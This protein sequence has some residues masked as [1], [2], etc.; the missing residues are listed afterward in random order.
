MQFVAEQARQRHEALAAKA[1]RLRS[2]PDGTMVHAPSIEQGGYHLFLSHV[3]GTG[4]DQMRIVKQRLLEMVPGLSIFLDVDDLEDISNLQGYVDRTQTVLVFCSRG[5][6]T[7]KNC[8]IELRSTVAKGKPVLALL[9]PEACHGGLT[10][11]EVREQLVK[12]DAYYAKWGFGDD[13]PRGAELYDALFHDEPVEWNRIG[14][15]QDVTLRLICARLLLNAS[16]ING[17]HL[18]QHGADADLVEGAHVRSIYV[19]R[20]LVSKKQPTL[21][22][23]SSSYHVYCSENNAGSAQLIEELGRAHDHLPTSK[24]PAARTTLRRATTCSSS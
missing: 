4:Q 23:T 17:P 10:T 1:R 3:W 22:A 9:E 16:P 20:E 2:R 21:P 14:C 15:F 13:G 24:S 19:Q 12:S 6:F 18:A 5:Y 7:S 8:M 11:E